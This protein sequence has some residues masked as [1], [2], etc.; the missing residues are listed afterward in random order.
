MAP[1][2]A[3]PPVEALLAELAA[4]R[5]ARAL[6][7]A[8]VARMREQFGRLSATVTRARSL[9][10]HLPMGVLLTEPTGAI[11][12]ATENLYRLL[13]L[14]E[15]GPSLVGARFSVLLRRVM[16]RF[17]QPA[18]VRAWS[19]IIPRGAVPVRNLQLL[20]ADAHVLELD[21]QPLAES[22]GGGWL[23]VVRDVTS[24]E[25]ARREVAEQRAF[26]ET[27]LDNLPSD[28][29][30]L[31]AEHRYRFANP[32]AIADAGARQW[33][34]GRTD[35]EYCRHRKR[36]AAVAERRFARFQQAVR[37]RRVV[38][39][40]EEMTGADGSVRTLRRH[41]QP[42]FDGATGALRLMI[43]YGFDFTALRAAQRTVDEQRTFYE[44]V[45][46]NM[47]ADVAVFD[48]TL[49]YR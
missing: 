45:L 27:I 39:W 4:E 32:A 29:A 8:E 33:I 41:L 20:R 13:D 31:D 21:A 14:S 19:R 42:V 11:L 25:V 1:A 40:E 24:R 23:V 5:A 3:A 9:A 6:A 16:S 30:V 26:Y 15:P 12:L 49:R 10:E 18:E 47:P 2:A 48:G 36:A 7:E 34:I 28:V 22:E 17:A 43:G 38:T 35:A 37:E 46:D 44:T